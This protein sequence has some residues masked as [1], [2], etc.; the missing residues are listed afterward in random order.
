MKGWIVIAALVLASSAAIANGNGTTYVDA[1]NREVNVCVLVEVQS[2]PLEDAQEIKM[3]SGKASASSFTDLVAANGRRLSEC[4]DRAKANGEN[5]YKRYITTQSSAKLKDDAK[6]VFI[7]WLSY[8]P[9]RASRSL[10]I[11]SPVT[12]AYANAVATMHVDEMTP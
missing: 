12:A 3:K 5:I 1:L 9:W 2:R 8:L 4:V 11:N 10:Q 6:A 7:A